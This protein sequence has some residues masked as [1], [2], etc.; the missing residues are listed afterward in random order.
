LFLEK[1]QLLAC[2]KDDTLKLID[3][4]QNKTICT[5]RWE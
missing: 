5:F 3:L 1:Q 4:R 2:F